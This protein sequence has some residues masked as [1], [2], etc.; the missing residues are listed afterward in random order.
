M[1]RRESGVLKRLRATPLPWAYLAA[2]LCSFFV[3]FFVE[4][5]S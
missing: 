1:I 3:A 2:V 5:A 4:V